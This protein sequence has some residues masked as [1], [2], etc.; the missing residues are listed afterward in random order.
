MSLY[1]SF[2][3]LES[4][5]CLAHALMSEN[6]EIMGLLLGDVEGSEAGIRHQSLPRAR[7]CKAGSDMV[8]NDL[9]PRHVGPVKLMFDSAELDSPVSALPRRRSDKQPDRVEIAPEQ[10]GEAR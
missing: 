3:F 9:V 7:H 6:E 10:L 5:A 2:R 8:F 4:E 1:K